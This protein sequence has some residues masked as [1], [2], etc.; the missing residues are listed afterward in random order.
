[1]L[2]NLRIDNNNLVAYHPTL[3]DTE[4]VTQFIQDIAA[5]SGSIQ[6]A[7]IKSFA[8][9]QWILLGNFGEPTAEII[10]IHTVTA[11]TGTTITLNTNTVF[12]HFVDT[13]VTFINFDQIEF[14]RA[15]TLA[16]VKVVQATLA[17]AAD[18][19][20]TTFA[21]LTNSTGF[22][23]F[24]FK[25][26]ASA[27]FS[28]YSD[29]TPYSG[30]PANS[31]ERMVL[32]AAAL[33]GNTINDDF[34]KERDLIQ[35]A[36]EAQDIITSVQAWTFELITDTSSIKALENENT[37]AVSGLTAAL[38][39]TDTNQ[40]II[41][42]KLG[43]YPLDYIDPREMEDAFQFSANAKLAAQANPGD[44][45]LTLDDV[46]AFSDAGTVWLG[47][48]GTVTYQSRDIPTNTLNGI[49]NTNIVAIV[50]IG[51]N[52]WQNMDPGVPTKYT[53]DNDSFILDVPAITSVAGM[54][55]KIRYLKAL[56]TLTSFTSTT[57]ILFPFIFQFY[58]AAKIELRK[59]NFDEAQKFM[60]AFNTR[61]ELYKAK[62]EVPLMDTQQYYTF[63]NTRRS[64]NVDQDLI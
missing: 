53:L 29:G 2:L 12:D 39:F 52:V 38:K 54:A 57:D 41:R 5:A 6:V 16:G 20:V 59:K 27:T 1:M 35:D 11:P 36:N 8:V 48:N 61:I 7:N 34:A 55:F 25:N 44:T 64:G 4:K 14:S 22:A 15:P 31:V 18:R 23:F 43:N 37:Y 42:F 46:S 9:G 62:Y 60:D 24:R 56:S 58:I 17:I 26:S 28:I 13:P 40:A 30:N 51:Y 47:S 63:G 19:L 21:D 49:A 45:S 3:L 50:P 10:R 32:A 33:T